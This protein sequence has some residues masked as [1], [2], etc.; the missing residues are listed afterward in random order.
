MAS[1]THDIDAI[2][3]RIEELRDDYTA[4]RRAHNDSIAAIPRRADLRTM[5]DRWDAAA[6]DTAPLRKINAA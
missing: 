3:A 1:T 2:E 5:D 4:T 6:R